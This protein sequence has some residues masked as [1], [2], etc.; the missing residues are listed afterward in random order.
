MKTIR[1]SWYGQKKVNLKLNLFERRRIK[2]VFKYIDQIATD[3]KISDVD[4]KEMDEKTSRL[5]S[6]IISARS[7]LYRINSCLTNY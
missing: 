4:V 7:A 2:K 6:A 5:Y 1:Y 3:V